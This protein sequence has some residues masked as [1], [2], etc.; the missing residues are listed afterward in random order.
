M[1]PGPRGPGASAPSAERPAQSRDTGPS[2][3]PALAVVRVGLSLASFV[4]Y[5][6]AVAPGVEWLDAGELSAA[7]ATLGVSHAPGQPLHALVGFAASLL[8]VG[9]IAFRVGLVSAAAAAA[10]VLGVFRLAEVL[11]PRR[12]AAGVVSAGVAATLVALAPV[13]SEQATRPEVYAPVLAL[14]TWGAV[15]SLRFLHTGS[16]RDA[17]AAALTFGLGAALHPLVAAVIALPLAAAI[18][19]RAEIRRLRRLAPAAVALA[20]LG[21][22][23]YAYL[24]L[25][26]L[27]PA[28]PL[29]LWGDPSTASRF[30]EVVSGKAYAANLS[31]TGLVDRLGGHVA[32]LAEGPGLALVLVGGIGLVFAAVTGLTGGRPLVAAAIGPVVGAASIRAFLADNPDVHG[33]V[34]AA[35]PILAAATALAID[36]TAKVLG[37]LLA[38]GSNRRAPPPALVTA[39]L[40]APIL[41]MGLGAPVVLVKDGG[42]RRHDDPLRYLDATWAKTKAGPGLYFA[43]A[44]H[45]LFAAL[46]E[47]LVGGDRP[48]LA[49]AA[50][51]LVTSSWFLRMLD[52]EVPELI[53]PW[54]DDRNMRRPDAIV[55]RL[56]ADNLAAGHTVAS[57]RPPPDGEATPVGLAFLYGAR[58]EAS[59][60]PSPPRPPPRYAGEVGRRVAGEAGLI[61][62]DYE[63]RHGRWLWAVIA[64]GALGRFDAAAQA[65][66]AES[67]AAP[68]LFDLPA[69][70]PVFI[71]ADWQVDALVLDAAA[72]AGLIAA[73]D[74]GPAA[75][76]ELRLLAAWHRSARRGAPTGVSP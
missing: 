32:L 26:A 65:R 38:P 1:N 11:G 15:L 71:F 76:F 25:R 19:A 3:P 8:P 21:L 61:R 45:A 5:A 33:Y 60:T 7:A 74:P 14:T 23:T 42:F 10:A 54:V 73:V 72:G 37:S 64:A 66:L 41:A 12:G 51:G 47:R 49:I 20:G 43:D 4:L 56:I 67:T 6:F 28:R 24:P 39:I 57:A 34:A 55:D 29:L 40:A 48:D 22:A 59:A 62:A 53:V 36:A 68:L 27:A 18:A 46:Y 44:D 17:L 35:L 69:V 31:L 50:R 52:R 70:T 63:L 30:V 16:A 75:P 58:P 2:P 13:L 9:E